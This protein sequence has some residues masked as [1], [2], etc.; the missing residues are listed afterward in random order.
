[1]EIIF[2][3]LKSILL[4][5]QR[6]AD[7]RRAQ[8]VEIKKKFKESSDNLC[9][10]IAS[11]SESIKAI[12]DYLANREPT[13]PDSPDYSIIKDCTNTVSAFNKAQTAF[14]S[15][16]DDLCL[17]NRDPQGY[18]EQKYSLLLLLEEYAHDI[19]DTT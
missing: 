7:E 17:I 3:I 12:Q 15:V 10:C 9:S 2:E 13:V 6:R 4:L 1:M 19:Q 14:L 8:R 16:L 11:G 18:E 5:V